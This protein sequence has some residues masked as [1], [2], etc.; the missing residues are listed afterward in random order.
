MHTHVKRY[1]L[2]LL[3]IVTVGTGI[4]MITQTGLGTTA[5]TSIPYVLSRLTALSFGT[6]TMLFNI[7]WVFL[8]WS[9]LRNRFEKKQFLQFFVGPVLG[10]TIDG[11]AFLLG[12]L[13]PDF[14]IGQ[15]IY[16][17]IGSIVLAFGVFMQ[18][19]AAV[20]YNPV[21]GI[22]YA[23]A[24]VINKQFGD[25]KVTFDFVLVLIAA[26]LSF[27]TLGTIV[28]LREGTI[29]SALLIGPMTN[30]FQ[31]LF[32]KKVATETAAKK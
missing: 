19:E 2:F 14:Y 8:Q 31:S 15:I 6:L 29:L 26:V 20:I 32:S 16:L 17:I 22:V 27:L 3:S 7:F 13:A 18:I 28:G 11:S 10:M 24:Q 30:V 25:I 5:V 21:E 12:P 1:S 4:T 23:I 9:I